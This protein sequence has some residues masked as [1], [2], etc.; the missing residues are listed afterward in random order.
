MET[1][2]TRLV[3]VIIVLDVLWVVASAVLLFSHVVPLTTAGKWMV[4]ILADVVALFA[5]FEYVGLRKL[6]KE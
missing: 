5:I 6:R 3:W 4:G 1:L 2:N